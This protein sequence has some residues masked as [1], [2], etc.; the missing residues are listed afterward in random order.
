M[1]LFLVVLQ[2]RQVSHWVTTAVPHFFEPMLTAA[3][4][5]MLPDPAFVVSV[6]ASASSCLPI[7]MCTSTLLEPIRA[8]ING[9][10]VLSN[11]VDKHSMSKSDVLFSSQLAGN[12]FKIAV[13][14][15]ELQR[16]LSYPS[17]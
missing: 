5:K 8:A 1:T 6:L 16:Q 9:L 2:V 12:A 7:C 4:F 14:W 3:A 10:G 13:C 15:H 17:T 11:N